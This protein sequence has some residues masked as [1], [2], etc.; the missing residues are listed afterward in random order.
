MNKK[1]IS[2]VYD[3]I[4]QMLLREWCAANDFDLS[5]KY[6]GARQD[7]SVYEFH[8]TIIYSKNVSDI[9]DSV[10]ELPA[11]KVTPIGFDILGEQ[12]EIPVLL[13]EEKSLLSIK[14]YYES[15][16]LIHFYPDFKPHISLSYEDK[17]YSLSNLKLP[18]FELFFDKLIVEDINEDL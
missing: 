2:I 6:S 5:F 1:Y 3:S 4:T 11:R 7:S 9:P 16:G 12:R 15:L 13:L 17:K 14:S 18:E 10:F 8:T